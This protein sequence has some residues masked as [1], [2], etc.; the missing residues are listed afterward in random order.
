[1]Y[2]QFGSKESLIVEA[3]E[4]CGRRSMQSLKAFV[5]K[6]RSPRGKVR[7]IFRW[8]DEWFHR[9][10]FEGCV[11]NNVA[12]ECHDGNSEIRLVVLRYK[13]DREDYIA[14]VLAQ[15]GIASHKKLATQIMLLIEGATVMA[16][17]AGRRDS[18]VKAWEAF[19]PSLT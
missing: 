5:D 8:H 17:A 6:S 14:S 19:E 9:P 13:R 7:A 18:A 11:F 2:N 4:E 3:L 12:G 1:M 15:E 10:G 16:Y